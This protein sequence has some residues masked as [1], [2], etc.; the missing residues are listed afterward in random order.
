[1]SLIPYSDDSLILND[2]NSKSLM[3]VN[4][5]QGT[6]S[7][8]QEVPTTHP[9]TTNLD[10]RSLLSFDY[11]SQLER[12]N[13]LHNNNNSNTSATS[14]IPVLSPNNHDIYF[15]D[16]IRNGNNTT[17]T[18]TTNNNITG[19]NRRYSLATFLCPQCG[20]QISDVNKIKLSH[21]DSTRRQF[22]QSLNNVNYNSVNDSTDNFITDIDPVDTHGIEPLNSN[23]SPHFHL[24]PKYFQLLQST[25]KHYS[26]PSINND[27]KS[28]NN[29]KYNKNNKNK[30]KGSQNE[31]HFQ[32]FIPEDLFIPGYF[33][34]FFTTLS[35][36][37][38]GARGSV[39]KVIHR[40]GNTPLGVFALKKI[41]IG[42]DMLWFNKCIREVK[43]LSL[44]THKSANLITYN[45]V[46][47]EMDK[48]YGVTT[49][50]NTDN[51]RLNQDP[52]D[53]DKDDNN[54][55]EKI[56]CLF[57]LQQ[58]CPG[59]NLEDCILIDV[60][61]KYPERISL[62]KRKEWFKE[63]R[64]IK[65]ANVQLQ[66]G[67]STLQILHI[68]QDISRGLHELHDIGLIHRDLKPSNCLLLSKYKD[69]T[70]TEDSKNNMTQDE[71]S[72]TNNFDIEGNRSNKM[73][74]S[75]KENYDVFP[76]VIIGDLGESQLLGEARTATGATGTI[77][78]TA[79]EVIIN[80]KLNRSVGTN[81]PLDNEILLQ[82]NEYTFAS[83]MY[84]FGMIVYF[85]VFGKLPFILDSFDIPEMKRTVKSFQINKLSMIKE[86]NVMNLK[87][88]DYRIFDIIESLLSVDPTK[89]PTAK[90][91]EEYVSRLI[92][93]LSGAGSDNNIDINNTNNN[94][95]NSYNGD[96]PIELPT[97]DPL[98]FDETKDLQVFRP[99][100]NI[101]SDTDEV[102]SIELSIPDRDNFVNNEQTSAP[103]DLQDN[104]SSDKREYLALTNSHQPTN[105]LHLFGFTHNK[106]YQTIFYSSYLYITI[107]IVTTALIYF[108]I[109]KKI[110]LSL[111][112]LLSMFLL[113]L[114]VNSDYEEAKTITVILMLLYVVLRVF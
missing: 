60:F 54:S 86:H 31:Q 55:N 103:F 17:A 38:N 13:N 53:C 25:H 87:P 75:N 34:K 10:R 91:L 57:I 96:N 71:C 59:G 88:I 68:V 105:L 3:I 97:V 1:M 98:N 48:S 83:D 19:K 18:T 49:R 101:Y 112:N 45:H 35:L 70:A 33:H 107:S 41:S 42:N 66:L 27:S 84:S 94:Y 73:N 39:F 90:Q 58:Y 36:L 8:F 79:P 4:A 63:M 32:S 26:L 65:R 111:L 85:I 21:N 23:Q 62:E 92:L 61:K 11:N 20:A 82:Y 28:N 37:G 6:L 22:L 30:T 12:Y 51:E 80:D 95:N 74:S 93:N 44:L 9:L 77:E 100:N 99:E 56:P 7:V 16:N 24:S 113:G 69:K 40:I 104:S 72:V 46:W 102:T 108:E 89:R 64:R 78:Y 106:Y 43:A 5:A 15:E 52:I 110:Y 2:P 50:M 47:L 14:F 114:S 29:N 109:K 67:L 76:T 81:S